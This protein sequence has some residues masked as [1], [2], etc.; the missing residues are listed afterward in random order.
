[1]KYYEG[2]SVPRIFMGNPVEGERDSGLRAKHRFRW[3]GEQFLLF[4]G[5]AFGLERNVF[6][7]QQSSQ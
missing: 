7:E 2:L 3:E 6:H 1:M 4:T 5:M